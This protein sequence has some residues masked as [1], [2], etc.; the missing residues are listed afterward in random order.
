METTEPQCKGAPACWWQHYW[1]CSCMSTSAGCFFPLL[2][3]W[4]CVAAMV[5]AVAAWFLRRLAFLLAWLV[6]VA[7][8]FSRPLLPS[9]PMFMMFCTISEKFLVK[10]LGNFIL[11]PREL[12]W[13]LDYMR[14][15]VQEGQQFHQ[16]KK[17]PTQTSNAVVWSKPFS[18]VRVTK[19]KSADR[20]LFWSGALRRKKNCLHSGRNFRFLRRRGFRLATFRQAA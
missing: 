16:E 6:C 12:I 10:S 18:E 5:V 14:K 3:E 11:Y 15:I 1:S 2:L 17:L 20:T 13:I 19:I 9:F 7:P 8:F 4:E